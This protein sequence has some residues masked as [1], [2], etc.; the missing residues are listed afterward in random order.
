M[1]CLSAVPQS[2]IGSAQLRVNGAKFKRITSSYEHSHMVHERHVAAGVKDGAT[3]MVL[4]HAAAE[5]QQALEDSRDDPTLLSIDAE[6]QRTAQ[7]SSK[8]AQQKVPT[9]KF[10]F[11]Q[12]RALSAQELPSSAFP[13]PSRALQLLHRLAADPG[14]VHIMKE[15]E[16][17][18][19]VSWSRPQ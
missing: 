1:L 4:G 11:Q 10:I 3:L 2:E 18:C 8:T 17:V 14:I 13:P 12:Y 7:R 19:P 9:G 5:V 15:N 6:L 16:Y